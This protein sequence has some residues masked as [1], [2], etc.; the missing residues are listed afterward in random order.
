MW[1]IPL[2]NSFSGTKRAILAGWELGAIFNEHSGMPTSATLSNDQ[3]FTGNSEAINSLG[4]QRAN[5][6]PSIPGCSGNP[7]NPGQPNNYI[8]AQCFSFPNPG[9]LGNSRR[10]MIWGP[11]NSELDL[12]LF[13]NISIKSDRYRVQFRAEAFN[14]LNHANFGMGDAPMFDANGNVNPTSLA[15]QAPTLTT[16]RQI[17]FGAKFVW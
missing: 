10:N 4:G 15:L 14:I 17:Q 11:W 8:K 16:S 13:K 5:Y 3:A 2:A 6:N 7:V 12:S 1:D 9:E